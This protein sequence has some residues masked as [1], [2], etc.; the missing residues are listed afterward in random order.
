MGLA[1]K[2]YVEPDNEVTCQVTFQRNQMQAL[3]ITAGPFIPIPP[4]DR[5]FATQNNHITDKAQLVAAIHFFGPPAK[6]A[7]VTPSMTTTD[8]LQQ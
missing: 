6:C 3:L 7:R 4:R 1:R 8:N 2:E 5:P